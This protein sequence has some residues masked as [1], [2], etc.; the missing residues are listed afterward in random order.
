MAMPS[1]ATQPDREVLAG[2]IERVTFHNAET[3]FCVLRVKARRI[4]TS[5]P[6]S[7]MRPRF[8]SGNGSRPRVTWVND[9]IH[10][11][12]FKVCFLPARQA[13]RGQLAGKRGSCRPLA[14]NFSSRLSARL[15]L[16]RKSIG[17]AQPKHPRNMPARL[18][19]PWRQ[20]STQWHMA[21]TIC[22]GR[23]RAMVS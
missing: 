8:P 16:H 9:R 14:D 13:E 7:V 4:A 19:P 17:T 18:I 23:V 1:P 12:Q 6:S 5:P 3:G 2:I 21:D 15:L 11:Q 20:A 22:A 10:G